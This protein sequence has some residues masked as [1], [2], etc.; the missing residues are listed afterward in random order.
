MRKYYSESGDMWDLICYKAYGT[1]DY[2]DELIK[3]NRKYIE[4]VILPAGE[5]L[6]LPEIERQVT[7]KLP[8]WQ[9]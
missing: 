1:S 9:R 5:E 4:Y 8:P 2:T 6:R 7:S 3:A